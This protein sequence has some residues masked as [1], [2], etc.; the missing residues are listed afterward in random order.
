MD[1]MTLDD[2]TTNVILWLNS[3]P[4]YQQE[5]IIEDMKERLIDRISRTIWES[6]REEDE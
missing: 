1:K 4:K 5:I 6:R 2:E 3:L